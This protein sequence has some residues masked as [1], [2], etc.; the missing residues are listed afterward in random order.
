MISGTDNRIRE[1]RRRR[2]LE[3]KKMISALVS[4]SQS[5]EQILAAAKKAR[6][7]KLE[8]IRNKL[9]A[10]KRLS[11]S[12]LQYLRES[13]PDLYEQAARIDQQQKAF[14][15]ALKQCRTEEEVN[16]VLT[17][18]MQI[19]SGMVP[20]VPAQQNGEEQAR[21]SDAEFSEMYTAAIERT[22]RSFRAREGGKL[23]SDEREAEEKRRE[24]HKKQDAFL[25]GLDI[26]DSFRAPSRSAVS[27]SASDSQKISI[28]A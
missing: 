19:T 15:R 5:T 6:A 8:R 24:E 11:T 12:E 22:H 2:N 27:D 18:H 17:S 4:D 26:S 10:G 13:A 28:R 20:A 21:V 1:S 25:R 9:K 14:E 16:R 23:V 7:N 3:S